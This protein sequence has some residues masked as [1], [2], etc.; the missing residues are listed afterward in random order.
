MKKHSLF[1]KFASILA[2][3]SFLAGCST[4]LH[5][6]VSSSSADKISINNMNQSILSS[7]LNKVGIFDT[8]NAKLSF[9]PQSIFLAKS[10]DT[11]LLAQIIA[12]RFLIANKSHLIYFLNQNVE[13]GQT[14][15]KNG[16]TFKTLSV[17]HF[18]GLQSDRFLI[19]NSGKNGDINFKIRDRIPFSAFSSSSP[20]VLN[21]FENQIGSANL[22]NKTIQFGQIP[23]LSYTQV[24][25]VEHNELVHLNKN[26]VAFLNSSNFISNP[27]LLIKT[28]KR[29]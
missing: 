10:A 24:E 19:F 7:N 2:I 5:H 8:K 21:N 25:E 9:L 15:F 1:L 28:L 26:E 6:Q 18:D 13:I 4:A 23:S 16:K 17:N 11:Q 22:S 27:N 20:F 12:N 14:K 3:S 29:M